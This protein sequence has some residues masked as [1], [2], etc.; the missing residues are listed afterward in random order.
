M[1]LS[2][3]LVP[4]PPP[5]P[6][7]DPKQIGESTARYIWLSGTPGP[8]RRAARPAFK[9]AAHMAEVSQLTRA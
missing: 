4:Q 7:I 2:I 1:F 8:H 9:A 5:P 3:S 6:H